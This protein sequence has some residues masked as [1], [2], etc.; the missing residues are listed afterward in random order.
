MALTGLSHLVSRSQEFAPVVDTVIRGAQ[1]T[2]VI[3]ASGSLRIVG[4]AAIFQTLANGGK[5]PFLVVP[6]QYHAEQIYLTLYS[7]IKTG[8]VPSSPLCMSR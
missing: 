5:I 4:I 1:E 2:L 7:N 8:I 6:D 3:G